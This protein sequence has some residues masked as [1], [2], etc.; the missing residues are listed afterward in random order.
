M[1]VRFRPADIRVINRRICRSPCHPLCY[2][3][4]E[5]GLSEL[6]HNPAPLE[7]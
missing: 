7:A 2:L 6:K 3:T 5:L 4:I 1:I